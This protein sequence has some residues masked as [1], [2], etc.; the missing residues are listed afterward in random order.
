MVDWCIIHHGSTTPR[1]V[2]TERGHFDF[3]Q[4]VLVIGLG[5]AQ[6]SRANRVVHSNS[7]A[8]DPRNR[9]PN[10]CM[11]KMGNVAR[12]DRSSKL[13]LYTAQLPCSRCFV[14]PA[15]EKARTFRTGPEARVHSSIQTTVHAVRTLSL[16]DRETKWK[17]QYNQASSQWSSHSLFLSSS[18]SFSLFIFLETGKVNPP[19]PRAPPTGHARVL[20]NAEVYGRSFAEIAKTCVFRCNIWKRIGSFNYYCK[21]RIFRMY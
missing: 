20:P 16:S 3:R 5:P 12:A 2:R 13:Q 21:S 19:P 14:A 17:F 4:Q 9:T 11:V 15:R 18:F 10:L 8:C 7:T 6:L 1:N